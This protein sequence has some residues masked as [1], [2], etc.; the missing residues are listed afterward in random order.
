M[1]ARGQ[2]MMLHAMMSSLRPAS[3]S[4]RT[5]LFVA[6][7]GLGCSDL[8]AGPIDA[9]T[10]QDVTAPQDLGPL[11]TG[12]PDVGTPNDLGSP[13]AGPPDTGTPNDLGPLDTGTPDVGTPDVG[14]PTDTGTP[15]D[16][17]PS[18]GARPVGVLRATC[19]SSDQLNW[20]TSLLNNAGVPYEVVQLTAETPLA[21]LTARALV[22]GCSV[23]PSTLE[24][25]DWSTALQ[26][27]VRNGSW[28]V[29]DG[30][31]Q[32]ALVSWSIATLVMQDYFQ[33]TGL[34]AYYLEP[35]PA[36]ATHILLRDVSIYRTSP[37][38]TPPFDAAFLLG[39]QPPDT[40][41]PIP[42]VSLA[43]RAGITD[44]GPRY[45]QI[46]V[47]LG[48]I[49]GNPDAQRRCAELPYLC[50]STNASQIFGR[51]IPVYAVGQGRSFALENAPYRRGL[52]EWGPVSERLHLNALRWARGEIR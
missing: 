5:G 12:T 19:T 13:D 20:Y 9:G 43:P 49:D 48:G 34:L 35:S 36:S 25:E 18:L 21:S 14:T 1:F 37:Q 26:T 50:S 22:L 33:S 31:A 28:I 3:W 30:P 17:A 29:L 39:F 51:N 45:L 40:G 27:A 4:A 16:A 38:T 2:G 42:F 6:L 52:W 7:L 41:L 10:A 15:T 32:Q 11:D 47:H 24:L 46:T 23:A 44:L 8:P